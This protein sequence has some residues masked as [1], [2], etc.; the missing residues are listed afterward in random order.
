MKSG[1][2]IASAVRGL[3]FAFGQRNAVEGAHTD[4]LMQEGGYKITF[5]NA[6]LAKSFINPCEQIFNDD[7]LTQ[8]NIF[9]RF[10]KKKKERWSMPISELLVPSAM[11]HE[12]FWI[13]P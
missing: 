4:N 7:F 2:V 10:R 6:V 3:A 12:K 13:C 11:A 9:Q 1:H 5:P 8:V